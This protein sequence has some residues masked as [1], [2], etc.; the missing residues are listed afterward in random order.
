ATDDPA[1]VD[2]AA[3]P[4]DAKETDPWVAERVEVEVGLEDSD[5]SEIVAGLS[6][7]DL[8]VT[9]GQQT[10]KPGTRISITTAEKELA[11][12][13]GLSAEEAL[14]AAEEAKKKRETPQ[15]SNQRHRRL[16]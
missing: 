2:D 16:P 7:S 13:A 9:L 8:V 1:A 10:L 11:K 6:E 12:S 15:A 4:A 3:P 14:K 5:E